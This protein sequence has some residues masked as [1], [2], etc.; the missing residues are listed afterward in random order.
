MNPEPPASPRRSFYESTARRRV[1]ALLDAGSF[2]EFLP[3]P[4]RVIS[5]HLGELGLVAA[6][7]DGVVIGAGRLDGKPVLV[8]AQEGG[9]IGGSVGEV[10]GAKIA[11]LLERA[12]RD[13]PATPSCYCW[14]A[15]A[16]VC[17]RPTRA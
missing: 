9:F 2:R 8:A 7:D 17:T 15:A 5:P 3:P 1:A 12:R 16:C 11:G 6:L 13:R 4:E 14:R 10:H